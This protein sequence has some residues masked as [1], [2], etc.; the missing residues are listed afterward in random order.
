MAKQVSEAIAAA[1]AKGEERR[2]YPWQ[3]W[4]NGKWWHLEKGTDF[5]VEPSSFKTSAKNW[6]KGHGFVVQ[7]RLTQDGEG[8]LVCFTP[9]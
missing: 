2:T 5:D 3:I 1:M 8:V 4:S 9:E 6:G 7:A